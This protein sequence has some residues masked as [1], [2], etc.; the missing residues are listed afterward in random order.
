MVEEDGK[1]VMLMHQ[2]GADKPERAVWKAPA[3]VQ[4]TEIELAPEHLEVFVG[5][6]ELAPGFVLTITLEDGRLMSQAT[7]Q[8]KVPIF[9]ESET[10][11]FLKVVDAQ[12]EFTLGEDGTA[13]RLVLFQAGQEI[14]AKRID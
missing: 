9:A 1:P 6:Y 4:R 10:R 8:A 11:F 5:R 2:D 13:T 12:L 7:G 14:P 3:R